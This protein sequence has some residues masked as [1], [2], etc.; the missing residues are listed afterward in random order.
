MNIKYKPMLAATCDDIHALKYPVLV[1]PKIDGIRCIISPDGRAMTRS[2]KLI[3]NN[4]I[5]K[6][7][8]GLPPGLDGELVV[9]DTFQSSTS[10]IMSHEGM[11]VFQYIVFDAAIFHTD[12][13]SILYADR[14]QYLEHLPL[15]VYCHKLIPQPI[16]N[17]T[18]LAD[19]EEDCLG[20]GYEGVI[21]RAPF[22]P[23]KYGRSTVKEGYMLKLKRFS[24]AE[25]IITG[26]DELMHNGNAPTTNALGNTERSSCQEGQCPSSMLGAL[27][28][29]GI[30]NAFDGVSFNVGSGF[31]EIQ[32][33]QIWEKR[34][35]LYGKL[36]KYKYQPFGVKDAPRSPIFL[37]F[38]TTYDL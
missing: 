20:K 37:G 3:P 16:Y 4:Y 38:R 22:S 24:D 17:A 9:G 27:Q 28:V 18:D 31:T 5:R 2:L 26:F 14:V 12:K 6:C 8:E 21:I 25:A 29:K 11:P 30:G 1:T 19:Y 35:S 32:R 7:L 33:R 36:I 10:A 34:D 23:Y 13:G 15:P